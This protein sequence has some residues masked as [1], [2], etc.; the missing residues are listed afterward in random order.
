MTAAEFD[1]ALSRR[2][3]FARWYPVWG[4]IGWWMVHLT[5]LAALVNAACGDRALWW[6][7]HGLTA[8][9]AAATAVAVALSWRVLAATSGADDEASPPDGRDRFLAW[10]GLLSS[11]ASLALILAE[12]SY[13]WFVDACA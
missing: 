13:V 1:P 11:A 5:A 6:T 12:G 3:A 8:V 10:L 2:G 4:G 7:M 9:T